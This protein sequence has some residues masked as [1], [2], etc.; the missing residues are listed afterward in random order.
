[1]FTSQKEAG[2][3]VEAITAAG[4]NEETLRVIETLPDQTTPENNAEGAPPAPTPV[5]M[6]SAGGLSGAFPAAFTET[7][8][9]LRDLKMTPN[10]ATFFRRG[11]QDGGV[12]VVVEVGNAQ[13]EEVKRILHASGG[14]S[15][16]EF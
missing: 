1:M 3:A 13:A 10:A 5:G 15:T 16:Q 6:S 11:V 7:E 8:D 9:P 2:A 12:L 14:R 4:L